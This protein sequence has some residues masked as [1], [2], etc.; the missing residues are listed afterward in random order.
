MRYLMASLTILLMLSGTQARADRVKFCFLFCEIEQDPISDSF[1]TSYQQVNRGASD[2]AEI[3]KLSRA[4]KIRL[5][6]ND[7][8]YLC[9]C[10]AW[11]NPICKK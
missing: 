2:S 3:K 1:C 8:L 11:N 10:K 4:P 5:N 6:A 9:K 7:V